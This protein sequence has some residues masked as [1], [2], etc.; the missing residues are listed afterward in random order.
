M[1]QR[2]SI[3]Q[4]RHIITIGTLT[5]FSGVLIDYLQTVVVNVFLFYEV[6]ILG[7]AI[8]ARQVFDVVFL[9]GGSLF[10]N[11]LIWVSNLTCKKLIPFAIGKSKI[12]EFLK[13]LTQIQYQI[14][15]GCNR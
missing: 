14:S 13:L 3:H 2:Q 9:N 10:S 8:F 4:Y 1:H 15:F 7:R 6:Y 12:I 11:A 5:V